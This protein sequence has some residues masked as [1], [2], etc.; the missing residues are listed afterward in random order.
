MLKRCTCVE[1]CPCL[2]AMALHTHTCI[3]TPT[4]ALITS[5]C[6]LS[7]SLYLCL[8]LRLLSLSL[9]LS[10]L[11]HMH[12]PFCDVIHDQVIYFCIIYELDVN[13]LFLFPVSMV[14]RFSVP[15]FL[16]LKWPG[17]VDGRWDVKIQ[18]L[19]PCFH[20]RHIQIAHTH[21]H[22][23]TNT[24]TLSNM[25]VSTERER[26]RR[27]KVRVLHP[28]SCDWCT[29]QY[30]EMHA[31]K[32]QCIWSRRMCMDDAE[33]GNQVCEAPAFNAS[34]AHVCV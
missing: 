12:A 19:T 24:H 11:T 1:T 13:L 4:D 9:S 6:P 23:R 17:T 31:G 21:M 25:H 20:L 3:W 5:V 28:C 30:A 33:V 16:A 22:V 7:L 26:E 34:D 10:T 18:E 15:C 14:L 2:H 32:R 8:S 27:V 29:D